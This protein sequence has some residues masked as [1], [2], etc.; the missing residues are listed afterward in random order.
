MFLSSILLDQLFVISQ[1]TSKYLQVLILFIA[2]MYQ[3]IFPYFCTR[4]NVITALTTNLLTCLCRRRPQFAKFLDFRFL[5]N[6]FGINIL[7]IHYRNNSKLILVLH[8]LFSVSF[9]V[10]YYFVIQPY[11][12]HK[13]I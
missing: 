6:C 4:Y 8:I 9:S 1:F 12:F 13:N 10:L 2:L 11:T 3:S 7:L 5:N